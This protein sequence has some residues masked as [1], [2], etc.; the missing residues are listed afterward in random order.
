MFSALL[1]MLVGLV[2]GL[3][4]GSGSGSGPFLWMAGKVP[5]LPVDSLQI[6]LEAGSATAFPIATTSA[7]SL[8]SI[9]IV[10]CPSCL[11]A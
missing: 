6:A 4:S 7:P 1:A 8:K 9:V 5:R 2:D 10:S 3:G 11:S